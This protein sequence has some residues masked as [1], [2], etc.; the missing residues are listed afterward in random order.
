MKISKKLLGFFAIAAIA[1][2][3]TGCLGFRYWMNT[4]T[5]RTDGNLSTV[6]AGGNL[7]FSASGQGITWKVSSTSDGTGPVDAGTFI[8]NTG[9]LTVSINE[10]VPVLY[11]IATSN[12]SGQSDIKQIRVV[13]VTGIQIT[14]ANESAAVG[15]TVQFRA[16]VTGNNNPDSAVTWGVSS[17]AAGT[18][19]V[20]AGTRIDSSGVLTIASNEAHRTLYITATSIVDPTKSGNT[21]VIVVVP[22]VTTVTVSPTG[23]S[24]R[25]GETLQF[26]ASV[27]GT[28]N[29]DNAVTWRVSSNAAGTGAVTPGT[30]IN[31]NGLLTVANNESVSPLHITATSSVDSTKSGSVTVTVVI[32]TVNSVTVN[33]SNQSI[34]AG[35]MIQFSAAVA[36][37]N[38]PNTSVTWRVS[39]NA[40]GTGAVTQGTSINN[41]G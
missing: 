11:V 37:T 26:S 27:T 32:P 31:A 8:S 10:T 7:R 1:G 23:Q 34:T 16:A 17:N 2:L 29:P 19:A 30:A 39:S 25:A 35:G 4:V 21:S 38:N 14:P 28:Y 18:G 24:V 33:P 15:R 12:D 36:G 13:T 20:T 6:V 5:I 40:A 3:L 22:T 41:N 9:L